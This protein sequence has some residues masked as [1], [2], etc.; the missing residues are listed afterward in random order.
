MINRIIPS[1]LKLWLV[2]LFVYL[3]L[4]YSIIAS[5]FF[6]VVAGLA[7]GTLMAWWITPGG[8]PQKPDVP[9]PLRQ[10]GRQLRQTPS[11]FS[12]PDFFKKTDR[13]Y[14]RSRP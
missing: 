11:R 5:I 3:A 8:E 1:A 13:R 10:L 14:P 2:F 9:Q 6:G 4:G 12:L 7:G